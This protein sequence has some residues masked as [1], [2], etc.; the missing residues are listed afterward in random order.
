ML[1]PKL[2]VVVHVERLKM[3]IWKGV[4]LIGYGGFTLASA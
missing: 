1:K 2:Q 4:F 3:R